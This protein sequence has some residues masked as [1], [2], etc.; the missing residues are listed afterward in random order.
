VSKNVAA[1]VRQRLRNLA[2]QRG[3]DFQYVLVRYGLERFL[4]RLSRSEARDRFVLKGAALFALWSEQP[5][6]ATRDVDLLGHGDNSI[7][8]MEQVFR[9][10]CDVE[11]EEDGLVFL[12]D[13]VQ[14]QVISSE[15]EYEG[16]RMT[17]TALLE[18]A[19]IRIQVDIGFGDAVTPEPAVVDYPVLLDFPTPKLSAYP[20]ETVVAEKFQ[21]MVELGIGNSRMKDFFDL[22]VIGREFAFGGELLSRAILATFERRKTALP[23]ETPLALTETFSSD[24]GKQTQWRAFLRRIQ[25]QALA[26]LPELDEVCRFLERFLMPLI[27]ACREGHPFEATW[28]P[29]GPWQAGET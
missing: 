1:S 13:T 14:G 3:E 18:R 23:D 4:Y 7:P 27:E 20:K 2:Q 12:A 29:G 25:P 26:P 16:L 15:D 10:I 19:R 17:L 28:S 11:V 21:A 24:S 8:H 22:W 6:R 9:Q 5:H